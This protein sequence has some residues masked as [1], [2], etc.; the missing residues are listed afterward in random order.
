MK[1]VIGKDKVEMKISTT[2]EDTIFLWDKPGYF[3][4]DLVDFSIEK[5]NLPENTLFYLNQGYQTYKEDK[6]YTT[7]TCIF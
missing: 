7:M 4:N 6:K 5:T 1:K 3:Q 2:N